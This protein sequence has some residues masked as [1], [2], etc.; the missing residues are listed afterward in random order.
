METTSE[1]YP[2]VPADD[3]SRT[4]TLSR[5]EEDQTLPHIGVVGDTYT[6]TVPGTATADRFCVIDMHVPRE[7]GRHPIV[8]TSRSLSSC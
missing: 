8:T 6:I 7:A 5:L 2:P 1:K 3:L 4:L